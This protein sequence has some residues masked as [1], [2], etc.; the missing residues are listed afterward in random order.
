MGPFFKHAQKYNNSIYINWF[1]FDTWPQEY[2]CFLNYK[3]LPKINLENFEARNYMLSVAEYW[4]SL[5]IDGFRIDHV[6]GP[7]HKFWQ[8]FNS[9][10][11]VKFPH[12]ILF[13]EAW[14]EGL[15]NDVYN[16]ISFKHKFIRK[17]FGVSQ[18][19]L[20]LE[21][22][23]VFNGILDFTCTQ[24]I[25]KAV[26]NG[27]SL[28]NNKKL[29]S[30]LQSHFTK[31]PSNYSTILFLDNHDMNRFLFYIKGDISILLEALQL[32][33]SFKQPIAVYYGTEQAM[34]N[35]IPITPAIPYSDLLVREPFNW[36]TINVDLISRIKSILIQE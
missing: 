3:Q 18:E 2:R 5:G 16:T 27:E 30:L 9:S 20:Q 1:V 32:L 4:L 15:Q 21:Y 35:S 14:A 23:H 12:S 24:L 29:N 25:I 19:K 22:K 36:N 10:I 28:T 31:Y 34:Q 26:L 11:R 33:L 6:I 7:S 8:F 13:G 17:L